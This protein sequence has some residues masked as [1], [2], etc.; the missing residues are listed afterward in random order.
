MN[1]FIGQDGS[2]RF[3][4]RTYGVE[5]V[6]PFSPEPRVRPNARIFLLA[7]GANAVE[8]HRGNWGMGTG[9]FDWNARDDRLA[10]SPLWKH[11]WGNPAN[12]VVIPASRVYEATTRHGERQWHAI[13]RRDEAPL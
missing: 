7:A 6:A 10:E 8:N 3:H 2:I 4:Y 1:S 12:H 11:L 13:R 9:R 5:E